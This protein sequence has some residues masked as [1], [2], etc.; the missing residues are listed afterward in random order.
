MLLL[1]NTPSAFEAV[2]VKERQRT[3]LRD[4]CARTGATDS[5][6]YLRRPRVT[7]VADVASMQEA[8]QLLVGRILL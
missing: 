4:T 3:S 8:A 1:C 2:C 6:Q 7:V 5:K